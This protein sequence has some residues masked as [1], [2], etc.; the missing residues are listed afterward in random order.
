M[1]MLLVELFC[2]AVVC[3]LVDLF[4]Y[5]YIRHLD[6]KERKKL[7]AKETE[8][9]KEMWAEWDKRKEEKK[10]KTEEIEIV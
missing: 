8:Y 1:V 5:K 6:K 10:K 4:T 3:M 7:Q 9:L 2:V